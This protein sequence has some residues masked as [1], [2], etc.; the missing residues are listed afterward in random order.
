MEVNKICPEKVLE[1]GLGPGIVSEILNK[2]NVEVTTLDID[3]KLN[4][5]VCADVTALPFSINL[6]I[7]FWLP[8]F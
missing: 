5:N 4:P 8:K 6:L 3:P 2:M 1:I 7:L